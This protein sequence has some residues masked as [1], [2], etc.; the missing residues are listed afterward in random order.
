MQKHN[1]IIENPPK[2]KTS[3]T[4][5]T[6]KV[7]IQQKTVG[8]SKTTNSSVQYNLQVEK[9]GE[10]NYN[11]WKKSNFIL[12]N[13]KNTVK[14]D[15][16]YLKIAAPLN[17]LEFSVDKYKNIAEIDNYKTVLTNW[18]K[19]KQVIFKEYTGEIL[20]ALVQKMTNKLLDSDTLKQ[21]LN[22][23]LVLQLF[24]TST[25]NDYLVYYGER[26]D[27][28]HYKGL[29]DTVSL[30]F[31]RTTTLGLKGK[32]LE[33]QSKAILNTQKI[34]TEK[35]TNY[36]KNK[37]AG[38]DIQNLQ[39]TIKSDLQLNYDTIWIEAATI[40]HS[41]WIADTNYEKEIVVT[42]KKLK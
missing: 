41:I 12:N 24:L 26:K 10:L 34:D 18:K 35:I 20:D 28:I 2:Y 21:T 33:L 22:R 27:T 1:Q 37:I 6:Y 36:F 32:A 16:L 31:K 19:Q 29:I 13:S 30:P 15:S 7:T 17:D 23:D 40:T 11:T 38:F 8:L 39:A 9:N 4:K 25:L 14:M 42:L 5:A 3:L